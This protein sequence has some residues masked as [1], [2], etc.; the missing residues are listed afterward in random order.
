MD[1]RNI[2]QQ[3]GIWIE[4][5]V[6]LLLGVLTIAL[7]PNALRGVYGAFL[8]ILGCSLLWMGFWERLAFK[9]EE[10]SSAYHKRGALWGR[11][12]FGLGFLLLMF[13]ERYINETMTDLVPTNQSSIESN[14]FYVFFGLLFLVAYLILGLFNDRRIEEG[15]LTAKEWLAD[16]PLL[17]LPIMLVLSFALIQHYYA[18]YDRVYP[19]VWIPC[20][21]LSGISVARYF[22]REKEKPM[23]VLSWLFSASLL[24]LGLFGFFL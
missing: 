18:A 12:G 1:N 6:L 21:I 3:W 16:L 9:R 17:A 14:S 2:R 7:K 8:I 5:G 4:G 13:S 10:R 19:Y 15:K 22:L 23:E 20:L 11:T 24:S